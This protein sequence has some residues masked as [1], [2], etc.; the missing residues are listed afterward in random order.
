[1]TSNAGSESVNNPLGFSKTKD[2]L[3]YEYRIV[4]CGKSDFIEMI[5]EDG[6]IYRKMD[7]Q[8]KVL[9]PHGKVGEEKYKSCVF[10]R[11]T[12]DEIMLMYIK[13]ERS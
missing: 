7:Y 12:L 5:N 13:G 1:M 3:M 8:Y 10:E 9:L 2:E 4:N 6:A 11:A